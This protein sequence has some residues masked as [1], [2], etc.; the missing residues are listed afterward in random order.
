M[1]EHSES[2]N[3]MRKKPSELQIDE[4]KEAQSVLISLTT[5]LVVDVPTA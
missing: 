4:C 2:M 5:L 1:P 3:E